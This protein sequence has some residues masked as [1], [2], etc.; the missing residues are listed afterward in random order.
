MDK[1]VQMF[2]LSLNQPKS[3]VHV[4]VC[5][6]TPRNGKQWIGLKLWVSRHWIQKEALDIGNWVSFEK[7]G[8]KLFINQDLKL[9]LADRR[10]HNVGRSYFW[11]VSLSCSLTEAL[12]VKRENNLKLCDYPWLRD[13]SRLSL[14][15]TRSHKMPL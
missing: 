15:I 14:I 2:G 12:W 8:L 1:K 9:W 10:K 3:R 7:G 6:E 13:E 11:H 4:C 5:V